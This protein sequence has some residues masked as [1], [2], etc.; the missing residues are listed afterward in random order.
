MKPLSSSLPLALPPSLGSLLERL[1]AY[2]G[3]VLLVSALNLG[4]AHPPTAAGLPL[5]DDQA[6]P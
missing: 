3:S 5:S 4:L 6:R 2:P 1:P